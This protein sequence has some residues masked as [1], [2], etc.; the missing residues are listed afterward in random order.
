MT[1]AR[2]CAATHMGLVRSRNEDGYGATGLLASRADG[3][4]VGAIVARLPLLAVVADGLGG[5]PS[6]DIASALAVEHLLAAKPKTQP[7]S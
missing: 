4:L 5:H 3:E 6:G 7:T 2:I 1:T